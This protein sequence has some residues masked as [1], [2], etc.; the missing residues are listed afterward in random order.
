[1]TIRPLFLQILVPSESLFCSL[2]FLIIFSWLF[3]HY[4]YVRENERKF[5]SCI[6]DVVPSTSLIIL[7]IRIIRR[8][9]KS[10][11]FFF[12][13]VFGG[14][15]ET[16]GYSFL[17]I[18]QTKLILSINNAMQGFPFLTFLYHENLCWFYFDKIFFRF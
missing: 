8:N 18:L 10:W 12:D 4:L 1:M 16:C 11:L 13:D 2:S 15:L 14:D 5:L 6:K 17:A 7:F 9:S 3:V